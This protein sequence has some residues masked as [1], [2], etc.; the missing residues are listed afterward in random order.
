MNPV[1]GPQEMK[2]LWELCLLNVRKREGLTSWLQDIEKMGPDSWKCVVIVGEATRVIWRNRKSWLQIRKIIFPRKVVKY[3]K[4]L[5]KEVVESPSMK[6]FKKTI[7]HGPCQP[8]VISP[9]LSWGLETME[10]PSNLSYSMVTE[11]N[12]WTAG[13]FV[14][15]WTLACNPWTPVKMCAL[16]LIAGTLRLS[17]DLRKGIAAFQ[18]LLGLMIDCIYCVN[19]VKLKWEESCVI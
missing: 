15:V 10:V 18:L 3:W 17:S 14:Q 6:E 8:V 11:V 19:N 5:P 13:E 16:G 2:R 4:K 1:E 9:A 7:G 12:S